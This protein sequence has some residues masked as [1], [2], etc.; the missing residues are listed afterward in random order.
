MNNQLLAVCLLVLPSCA[1]VSP[2]PSGRNAPEAL[3]DDRAEE[4]YE[5]TARAVD[6]V[7]AGGED[8]DAQA[9]DL[10]RHQEVDEFTI[11]A[12]PPPPYG[13]WEGSTIMNHAFYD[14]PSDSWWA[15]SDLYDPT[16]SGS[17]KVLLLAGGA[18][19]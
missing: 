12:Y 16:S 19:W 18:G 2:G 9:A 4:V 8:A 15:L 10:P 14:P 6:T 13:K 11:P 5:E 3:A 17:K 7:D 1:G